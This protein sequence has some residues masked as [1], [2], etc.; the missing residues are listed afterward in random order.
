MLNTAYLVDYVG[1]YFAVTR[2]VGKG[3]MKVM[4]T[5]VG[6]GTA[7]LIATRVLPLWMGARGTEF[8]W[9]YMQSALGANIELVSVCVHVCVCVRECVHVCVCV[10]E[11]VYVSVYVSVATSS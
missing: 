9:K 11:C 6:W 3:E 1:L 4:A 8:D 7:Q 5:A 10:R 2:V